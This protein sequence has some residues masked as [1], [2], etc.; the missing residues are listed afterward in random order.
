MTNPLFYAK[1][2]LFGVRPHRN[3]EYEY[4]FEV[5]SDAPVAEA[6]KTEEA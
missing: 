6:A 1:I 5:V 2:L 4:E 3:V